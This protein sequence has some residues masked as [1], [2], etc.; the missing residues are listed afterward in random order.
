[1]VKLKVGGGNMAG[2]LKPKIRKP[3]LD[4]TYLN[5]TIIAKSSLIK[6]TENT[7]RYPRW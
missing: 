2:D 5:C 3:A 7:D 6:G 4:K 1:M